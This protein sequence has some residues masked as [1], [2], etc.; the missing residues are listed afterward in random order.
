VHQ[1]IK[2][3][4][5]STSENMRKVV[6]A[7]SNAGINI[8]AI[9]PDFQPPHV[10]VLVRHKEPYKANDASDPFNRALVALRGIGLDPT[11]VPSVELV[12]MPNVPT[13]LQAAIDALDQQGR[14]LDSVLVMPDAAGGDAL[15]SFGIDTTIDD[16]WPKE[17]ER[18]GGLVQA[19]VN[20]VR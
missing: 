6:K 18:L 19:A 14:V 11:V 1:Q 10:R 8:E 15:V 4:P 3:S 5:D 20:K 2:A 12:S 7:L 17:A 13:A 16:A 9:G